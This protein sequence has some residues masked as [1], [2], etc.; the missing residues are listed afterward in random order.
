MRACVRAKLLQSCLTLCNH[1]GLDYSL[2]GSSVHG[3]LQ[4]SIL[5][6]VA[7]PSS[8]G[9]SQPRSR[10]HMLYVSY[11]GRWDLYHQHYL[12]SPEDLR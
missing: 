3:I 11:I 5:E 8:K 9:F 12:G 4:A 1:M 10:T 2:S 6:W 7:M